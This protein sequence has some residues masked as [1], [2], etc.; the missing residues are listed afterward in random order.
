MLKIAHRGASGYEPENTLRAFKKAI[1][2]GVSMIEL[3]VH[4]CKTG[5]LV[6]IHDGTLQRTTNGR[7]RVSV[8][9][10]A[11]LKKLDAGKSEQVPTLNE[12]IDLVNRRAIINIELKGKNIA[13]PIVI[14]LQ[15]YFKAGYLSEDF[16]ISSVHFAE[17]KKI[18]K[19]LPEVKIGVLFRRIFWRL[20][21]PERIAVK[22]KAD[23][24]IFD[25]GLISRSLIN[26]AKQQGLKVFVFTVND[27]KN[28]TR[29]KE[30]G[31]D[32]IFSNFPDKI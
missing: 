24:I 31:V 17:L 3:D 13:E 32:G 29:M 18:K 5:E 25:L 20:F 1:D 7:G 19:A 14:L 27:H 23:F 2:L 9:T 6:V 15:K 4:Q 12:V 21:S 28:I 10:L 11:E 26:K 8:K 22:L 16:L 30:W